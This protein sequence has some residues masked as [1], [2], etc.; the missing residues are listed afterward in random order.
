M[1]DFD[2]GDNSA[3]GQLDQD[4]REN[5]EALFLS[6]LKQTT[7]DENILSVFFSHLDV[8]ASSFRTII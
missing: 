7:P 2:R 4:M 5:F 1:Q 8:M 3:V 6:W